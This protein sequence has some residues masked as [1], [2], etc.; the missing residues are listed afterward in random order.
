LNGFALENG[1]NP[2]QWILPTV[3][4]SGL[5][6]VV[7]GTAKVIGY[8]WQSYALLGWTV[9]LPVGIAL[10]SCS[11][12]GAKIA[13][14]MGGRPADATLVAYARE[15]AEKVG[16]SPPEQVFQI[17]AREPNAFAASNLFAGSTTVA[18]T[19][20][21]RSSLTA[22]EL[23]AVLAH[24]MG[25]LQS[26]DV[27]RNMHVA[28]ATAGF[29]GVY[30]MGR[31][32][33][34]SSQSES[35]KRKKKDDDDGGSSAGLGLMLMGVGLATQATAH[36]L[37]LSASRTAEIAA[38]TAAARAFGAES[39]ISALRKID[40]LAARQPADLRQSKAAQGF[41]FAMISNGASGDAAN[42]DTTKETGSSGLLTKVGNALRTHPPLTQ[43]VAALEEA[44]EKG[45][46][47]KRLPTR[48]GLHAYF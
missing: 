20:G 19:S 5:A 21:L 17:D 48:N 3:S 42:R 11:Q 16:V 10:F 47:P 32:L 4:Y 9:A 24:E 38:D 34:D 35:G 40:G 36:M 22:T 39:M 12:G 43:R 6:A 13:E 45:L 1:R 14:S 8:S 27:V 44:V 46:V 23:K 37:R 18:V 31:W 29:G 26:N 2:T 28:V 15:A 25:H 33:L 30:N 41:A 7:A